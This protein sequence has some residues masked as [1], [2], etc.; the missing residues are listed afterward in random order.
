MHQ[1]HLLLAVL[2]DIWHK[3]LKVFIV[4]MLEQH[5]LKKTACF[6]FVILICDVI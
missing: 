1:F 3:R 6:V 5:I 2:H 4:A